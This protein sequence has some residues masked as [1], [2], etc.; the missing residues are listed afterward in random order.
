MEPL[1]LL[2]RHVRGTRTDTAQ[3][4]INALPKPE[5]LRAMLDAGTDVNA[6]D[7]HGRTVLAEVDGSD[8]AVL[9]LLLQRGATIYPPALG[10]KPIGPAGWALLAGH[11]AVAV[12]LLQRDGLQPAD[13]GLPYYAAQ[14]G[15]LPV[16]NALIDRGMPL[17]EAMDAG[18]RTA[19]FVAVEKGRLAAVRLLLERKA[20][21]VNGESPK[22]TE[23][24]WT[25]RHFDIVSRP[26]TRQ[27]GGERP[28]QV[29]LYSRQVEMARELLQ[30]GADPW[31]PG[32]EP[33]VG[34][35]ESAQ[36]QKLIAEHRAARAAPARR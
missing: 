25:K 7:A 8:A 36:L 4:L 32:S 5:V 33:P 21:N 15:S 28:L 1:R 3:A 30:R 13:C 19:L 17:Q 27:V 35:P 26:Y 9:D 20:A 11:D 12:A 24:G 18:N 14:R 29:A 16:L 22:H 6:R 34:F 31:G 23:T 10:D 2:L